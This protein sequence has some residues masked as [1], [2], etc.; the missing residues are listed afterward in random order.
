MEKKGI[1]L[2][3]ILKIRKVNKSQFKIY[4]FGGMWVWRKIMQAIPKWLTNLENNLDAMFLSAYKNPSKA[5]G[6]GNEG[7][8]TDVDAIKTLPP[9]L[10][11][12][13]RCPSLFENS[14]GRPRPARPWHPSELWQPPPPPPAAK[15]LW[16]GGAQGRGAELWTPKANSP[17]SLFCGI[18]AI[19]ASL[20]FLDHWVNQSANAS[21]E[22]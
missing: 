1:D 21:G 11:F 22:V 14:V 17:T 8:I 10:P 20:I 9:P 4:N 19:W 18:R 12:C 3:L 7:Q 2:K 6:W 16:I 15:A 5:H 13:N